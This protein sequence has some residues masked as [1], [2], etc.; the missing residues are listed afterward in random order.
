MR[1]AGLALVVLVSSATPAAA[2]TRTWPGRVVGYRDLTGGSGYHHAVQRAVT[3]WNDLRLGIRFVPV[4]Q[5]AASVQ[6]VYRAG[7]CLSGIAGSAP[8][9]F[10]RS[11]ARVVVRSCPEVVRPLLVAHELGRVLGLPVDDSSCSLMNSRGVSDGASYALPKRCAGR[12]RPPWL[13][14]LVDPG[15]VARARAMY[16]EPASVVALSLSGLETPRLDWRQPPHAGAARTIVARALG[17]C[18]TA[19]DLAAG[20]V[21]VI[22]D[23]PGFAGRHWVVDTGLPD[24]AGG[25]CYRV[26]NLNAFGRAT[27]SAPGV[28]YVVD[29]PPSSAFTVATSNPT[30]GVPVA[31]AD[32]SSDPDGTIVRWQWDFG[33]PGSGAA[34]VLDTADPALARAPQHTYA[35]A[36]S[37]VV[38]LTVTDNGGRAATSSAT[39]T[40]A[41]GAP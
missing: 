26:F 19:R 4:A 25:Y 38:T 22:Y 11:G 37:Y 20:T 39:I 18:P 28:T 36:G 32:G 7:R 27:T 9:G 34:N 23:K 29:V 6:I 21:A 2:Q 24:V 5:G 10:Q 35:T 15:T 8:A 31:F 16:A 41:V 1:F 14:H 40:V 17:R 12:R 13:P 3:A 33:D 30:A